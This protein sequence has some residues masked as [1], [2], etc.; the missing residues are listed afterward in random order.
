MAHIYELSARELDMII[1]F[2][3]DGDTAVL[4]TGAIGKLYN[5]AAATGKRLTEETLRR[6]S[7][8]FTLERSLDRY[9]RKEAQAAAEGVFESMDFDSLEIASALLYQLQRFQAAKLTKT[10][11]VYILY[12]MYASWLASKRK[13]LFNEHPVAT[14]WGPQLW[15]VYSKIGSPAARV[16]YSSWENITGQ[17]PAVAKFIE[18]SAAK[19]AGAREK[20][21]RETYVNSEPYRLCTADKNGG[22]WNKEIPDSEIYVWKKNQK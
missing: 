3:R 18:N 16:P 12:E 9:R 20:E 8:I 2:V 22:K 19:Y 5:L 13:R 4:E 21:M 17:S 6:Q 14:E 10:K 1:G 15:R 11:I 7:R